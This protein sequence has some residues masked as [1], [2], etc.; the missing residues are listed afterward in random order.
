MVGLMVSFPLVNPAGLQAQDKY[1][2]FFTDKD[3]VD[4]D[5]YDY[6]DSRTIQRRIQM[7]IPLS[8]ISDLPVREDYIQ[9]VS[10]MSEGLGWDSRWLNGIVVFAFQDQADR[11]RTLDF[12]RDIRKVTRTEGLPV[13]SLNNYSSSE[14]LT[15]EEQDFLHRQLDHMEGHMFRQRGLSGKGIRIAIFDIGFKG[16]ETHPAFSHL[17]EK[18]S[19]LATYDFIDRDEQ[20]Y[21]YNVH[22]T[23]V[24]SCIA[25]IM[26]S[27][28]MGLAPDA[29]FLLARTEKNSE[30]FLEEENWLAAAEWADKHGADI[31]N[32]SLAYTHQRYFARDMDG[33][34]SLV[35]KAANIAATKGMLV[36]NA[37]GNSGIGSW[38][39]IATPSDADSVL[40]IGGISPE[41]GFHADF[42]SYGPTADKRMKPNLCA[43]GTAL[44]ANRQGIQYRDGTSF[45]CPLVT[46]FAACAWQARPD[47]NNMELFEK[48]EESGSLFPYFDYAHGFGIPK[49]NLF[50]EGHRTADSP[51]FYFELRDQNLNIRVP[52]EL[53]DAE[54]EE[55]YL[56]YYHIMQ[57][58]GYLWKYSVILVQDEEVLTL[59]L[60][61]MQPG[62]KINVSFMGYYDQ[63]QK[64]NLNQ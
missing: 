34:T 54:R 9:Q 39:F 3:G 24:M 47:L 41:T 46:G 64:S 40:T 15:D 55:P 26:D 13:C 28:Q 57:P 7:G 33:I 35:A 6:F 56:M 53:L 18:G 10:E 27:V 60:A 17:R 51:T 58:D 30:L 52:S 43:F 20:V 25:G 19:I 59:D 48:L 4:F 12:V 11:I 37:A 44:V 1:W 8:D 63:F 2:V 22:G 49:A 23:M 16:T 5:P 45:A 32:S 62:T 42:S 14:S 61:S 31:I 38:H 36:V 29:E 21:H 50:I